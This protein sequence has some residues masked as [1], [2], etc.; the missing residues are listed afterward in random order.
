MVCDLIY[1]PNFSGFWTVQFMAFKSYCP[2]NR[3]VNPSD[4]KLLMEEYISLCTGTM[5]Y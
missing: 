2:S 5:E 4:F 3:P 1:I